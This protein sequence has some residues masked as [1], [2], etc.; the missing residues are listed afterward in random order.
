MK[1]SSSKFDSKIIFAFA[2]F[3]ILGAF[4]FFYQY[5]NHID[6]NNAKYFITADNFTVGVAIEF[7]NETENSKSQ[8][9]DFGDNTSTDD[10]KHTFHQ[11]SKPGE[12][13]AKLIINGNC[14]QERIL[15]ISSSQIVDQSRIPV[16]LAPQA[17]EVGKSIKFDSEFP[18]ALTWEWSFG[19]TQ[20]LDAV[21]KSEVYSF[22]TVGIKKVTLIINGDY[23]HVATKTI[24]VAPKKITKVQ[25]L[26]LDSYNP[27]LP[28]EAFNLP[29]GSPQK[30]PLVDMMQYIPVAPKSSHKKDSIATAKKAPLISEDQFTLLLRGVANQNKTKEDFASYLCE[31]YEIPVVKNG[32]EL[33]TFTELCKAIAGKNIKLLALRLNKDKLNC[34]KGVTINYKVKKYMIWVTE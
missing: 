5:S 11:Y 8:V 1:D 21:K 31:D 19:E 23:D 7:R 13:K 12:Y 29:I 3:I 26:D 15:K 16:I 24:Y 34:I 6:C 4:A 28:A 18:N 9:W 27:E 2:F 10:R 33:I 22:K 25:K 32:K 14:V 20:G 30:D 17:V